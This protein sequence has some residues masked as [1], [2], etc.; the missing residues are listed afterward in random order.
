MTFWR[1]FHRINEDLVFPFGFSLNVLLLIIIK[2]VK[3]PSLKKYNILLLQCCCIDMYQS[4][5]TFI[6]KPVTVM[7]ERSLYYLSNGF[8]RPIGGPIEMLGIILWSTSVFLC[9]CSM[10]VSFVFRHRMVVLN[11]QITNKFYITC[12]SIAV[13]NIAIFGTILWKFH[14][15]DNQN[16]TYLAEKN[17]GWLMADDEGKV[18]AA[19]VCL[20]VSCIV[21]EK[22][23]QIN[24]VFMC[25]R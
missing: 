23:N 16:M 22:I 9:I 8:L 3:V 20:N 6:V 24:V 25:V 17:F 10:P 12:L 7:H 18:K 21:I 11:K 4:I 15:I 2:N 1:D 19:S 5:I 14:Y 13:F